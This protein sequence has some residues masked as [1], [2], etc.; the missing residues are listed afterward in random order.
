VPVPESGIQA[1]TDQQMIEFQVY[2]L[3]LLWEI[4]PHVVVAN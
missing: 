3:D 2:A 4:S 1:T